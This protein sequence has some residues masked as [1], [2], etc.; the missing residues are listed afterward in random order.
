MLGADDAAE[1]ALKVLEGLGDWLRD[2][3]EA[4]YGTRLA[5]PHETGNTAFTKKGEVHYAIQKLEEGEALP[6]SLHVTWPHE[7]NKVT[8]LGLEVEVPFTRVEDGIE[9]KIPYLLVG[10]NPLA[11][12][13]RLEK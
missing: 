4:I 11:L 7:V 9:I 6:E 10:T 5:I 8:L 13:F 12:A 2:N 1:T 3:G